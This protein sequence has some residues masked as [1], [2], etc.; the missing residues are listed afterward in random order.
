MV[1]YL[2]FYLEHGDGFGVKTPVVPLLHNVLVG[3]VHHPALLDRLGSHTFCLKIGYFPPF[4]SD[5]YLFYTL[6]KSLYWDV[7]VNILI[8]SKGINWSNR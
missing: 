6:D 4:F 3:K 2:L 8:E 7:A 5:F 1:A